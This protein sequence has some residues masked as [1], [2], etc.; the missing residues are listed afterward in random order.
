MWGSKD[1]LERLVNYFETGLDCDPF[2][3]KVFGIVF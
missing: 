3:E 2:K 1:L